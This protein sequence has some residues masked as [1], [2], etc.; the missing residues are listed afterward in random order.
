MNFILEQSRTIYVDFSPFLVE[1]L[2]MA[3]MV[4]TT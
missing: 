4:S 2:A 3:V 1:T